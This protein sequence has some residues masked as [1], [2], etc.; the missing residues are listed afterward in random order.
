MV[1]LVTSRAGYRSYSSEFGVLG[2]PLWLTSGVIS[3]EE[4]TG[5]RAS[6]VNVSEFNYEIGEGE[7]DAI[8]S[9]VATVKEHHPGETVWVQA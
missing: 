5:L 4:L 2:S 9:A 7:W 6:G 1:F 3:K 8:E